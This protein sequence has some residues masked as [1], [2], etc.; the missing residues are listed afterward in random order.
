MLRADRG[1][2]TG[3]RGQNGGDAA[4]VGQEEYDGEER[5]LREDVEQFGVATAVEFAGVKDGPELAE[6]YAEAQ[7][8]CLPSRRE[9]VR[10]SF[11]RRCPSGFP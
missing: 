3:A 5:V 11:S 7:V 4:F 6:C 9:G 8:L 2:G 10:S 1:A